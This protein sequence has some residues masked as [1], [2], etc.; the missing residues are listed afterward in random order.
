MAAFLKRHV[1]MHAQPALWLMGRWSTAKQL[2]SGEI[3]PKDARADIEA[4]NVRPPFD[5]TSAPATPDEP[6]ISKG[7]VI[8]HKALILFTAPIALVISLLVF[9]VALVLFLLTLLAVILSC[10]LLCCRR[11]LSGFGTK[12]FDATSGFLGNCLLVALGAL[13]V[14]GYS[15]F[16]FLAW[17]VLLIISIVRK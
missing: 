15:L 4:G 11:I 10:F 7:Q 17:A 9:A 12:I 14:A 13:M 16:L 6:D 5:P 8:A 2:E 3:T 1:C